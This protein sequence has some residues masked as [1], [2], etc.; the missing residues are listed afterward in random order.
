MHPIVQRALKFTATVSILLACSACGWEPKTDWV[1]PVWSDDDQRVAVLEQVSERKNNVLLYG[2]GGKTRYLRVE[3]HTADV[4]SDDGFTPVGP[5]LTG[6]AQAFYYMR[7]AGYAL[8]TH[9][10]TPTGGR[11][12]FILTRVDLS[13]GQAAEIDRVN[14]LTS[15]ECQEGTG[16]GAPAGLIGVPSPDASLLAVINNQPTCESNPATLRFLDALSLRQVGPTHRFDFTGAV[17]EPVPLSSAWTTEGEFMIS[18]GGIFFGGPATA[19]SPDGST[20]TIEGT[21][22]DCFFPETTSSQT[23]AN[24]EFIEV[25]DLDQYSVTPGSG[26][27]FGCD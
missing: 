26:M 10:T 21:T 14:A 5:S 23:N 19:Y 2:T 18:N 11:R 17:P 8:V 24:Q 13:T 27:S 3:I 4:E 15:L 9:A 25:R 16:F 7:S 20:R 12:T 22:P 6:Q 1:L